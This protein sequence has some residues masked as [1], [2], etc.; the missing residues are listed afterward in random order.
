MQSL[1][2]FELQHNFIWYRFVLDTA[3][4]PFAHTI[5]ERIELWIFETWTDDGTMWIFEPPWL[6]N[7]NAL[8]ESFFCSCSNQSG[9][10]VTMM[11]RARRREER[12]RHHA[13]DFLI[14]M[15]LF[16][17]V[18]PH[19]ASACT[20]N[21]KKETRL[22][23]FFVW[24]FGPKAQMNYYLPLLSYPLSGPTP[25]QSPFCLF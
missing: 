22:F 3:F 11:V 12:N 9:T 19:S 13:R 17:S 6:M 20:T 8:L 1:T 10:N 7:A 5:T 24:M 21:L 23:T 2:E 14:S 18:F 25:P 15:F 16:F 4:L